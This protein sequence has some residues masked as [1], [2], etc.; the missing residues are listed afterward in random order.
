MVDERRSPFTNAQI[1]G[2]SREAESLNRSGHGD[3]AAWLL[4]PA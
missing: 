4:A 1:A 3:Q 2:W